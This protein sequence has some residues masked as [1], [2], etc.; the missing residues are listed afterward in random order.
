[1]S[2]KSK[3][4]CPYCKELMIPDV[5]EENTV[6]RDK[7]KCSNSKCNGIIYACMGIGCNDYAKSGDF[8]DDN[9]CPE[10]TETAAKTAPELIK[11]ALTIFVGSK[12][13]KK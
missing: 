11:F 9:L 1:M 13:I 12:T 8:W 10:C 4:K 5:I 3:G 2:I 7:C 6:R